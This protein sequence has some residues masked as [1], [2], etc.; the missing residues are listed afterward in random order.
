MMKLPKTGAMPDPTENASY[1][2]EV[3]HGWKILEWRGGEWWSQGFHTRFPLEVVQWVKLPDP[4]YFK[5]QDKRDNAME[6]DL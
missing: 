3:Y 4:I 2:A 6:Y 1:A 5:L